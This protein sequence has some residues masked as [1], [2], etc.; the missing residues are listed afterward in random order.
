MLGS[1]GISARPGPLVEHDVARWAR[2]LTQLYVGLVLF[3]VSAGMQVR[4]GLGLDPWDVLH[5]GIAQRV[6]HAIGTVAIVLGALVL[7]LWWPLRQR[8]GV[9]TVSNVVVVGLALNATL[10]ALPPQHGYPAK[11][12]MLLGAIVL[13]GLASGMYISAGLGPGPRDGLMTG[14]ARRT[15]LSVRIVRTGIELTVLACGWLLGG[16]VG[17]GTVLFAL[18]IGPITQQFM[19]VLRIPGVPQGHEGKR[20]RTGPQPPGGRD[21]ACCSDSNGPA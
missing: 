1:M 17:V 20:P 3:G 5:Q 18:A 19:T 16:S 7:L 13:C 12:A 11:I 21:L 2:R 10:V 9:G 15:G 4:A 8:P 6:H 14:L